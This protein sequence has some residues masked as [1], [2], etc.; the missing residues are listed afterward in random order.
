MSVRIYPTIAAALAAT[1]HTAVAP[2]AWSP[3]DLLLSR[4]AFGPTPATRSW[5]AKNGPDAWYKQQVAYG[6]TYQGYAGVPK[7]RDLYPLLAMTPFDTRQALAEQGNQYGWGAMDALTGVTLAHQAWSPA[8][9]Y[10][11]LVDVFSNHLNVPNH[12]GDMWITRHCYDRDVIR[13]YAMGSFTDMLIAASKHPAMLTYLNLAD[14]TKYAVNENYGR[15][16][17]ELHTV[18]RHYSESDV[19][20]CARMLTGRTTDRNYHYVYDDYVHPTGAIT[21]LGFQHANTSAT[22]GEAAGDSMLRYLAGHSYTAQNLAQKLCV[23]LVSDTPSADLVA[24]VAKAYL[25]NNTQILPMVSTILRS[26]EFWASRGKKVRRPAENL[27]ATM[28]ILDVGVSDWSK[29]L[30]TMHWLTLDLGHC[31]LEWPAPNGYP[32]A[33]TSW[34]STGTL[35]NLWEYHGGIIGGWWGGLTHPDINTLYGTA[36]TTSGDAVSKLTQRLTNQPWTTAHTSALQTTLGESAAKPMSQSVLR[37]M[38][39]SLAALILDSPHFALA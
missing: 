34:R 3:T 11:V 21:V 6:S 35:L 20:N 19:K 22:G 28:R 30:P 10:E 24:A 18:G 12:N 1:P 14:S 27:L 37:W 17:L 16:V 2:L 5:L 29:A 23:R 32:A 25:D 33:A 4:C 36:P 31:P 26:T 13:K 38:G 9:L 7:A 39:P 8:Q 15:E